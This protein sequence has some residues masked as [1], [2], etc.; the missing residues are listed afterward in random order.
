VPP[1]RI[2]ATKYIS[3][4]KTKGVAMTRP[5]CPFPAVAKYRGSGEVTD[6]ANFSCAVE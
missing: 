6:A 2:I 5:L 4:D 3:N 1:A